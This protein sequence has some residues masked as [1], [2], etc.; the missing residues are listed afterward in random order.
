MKTIR[1]LAAALVTTIFQISPSIA[2]QTYEWPR[3]VV[4]GT[5]GTTTGSFASTNGWAPVLQRDKGISVRIVPEGNEMARYQRLTTKKTIQIASTSASEIRSQIEG[6]GAYGSVPAHP[7]RI[8]W[9]HNDTPWGYVTSATSDLKSLKDLAKGGY[10]VSVGVFSPALVTAVKEGLPAFAGLSPEEA[11]ERFIF[12]PASSYAENCRSVVEGKA[13][14]AL[15]SPI[16]SLLSEMEAAPGGIRWLEMDEEDIEAWKGYIAARPMLIPNKISMG[17]E[18]ARGVEGSTSN[19]LYMVAA[20]ADPEFAYNMA[21]WLAGSYDGYKSTHPLA[22]RMSADIFRAYLDRTP[23]PVHEGTVRYLKEAG[24]WSP[25]DEA[26][27]A[28]AITRMD[29]WVAARQAALVEAREAGI[30]PSPDN[31]DFVTILDKHT[32]ELSRFRSRL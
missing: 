3:L 13:D 5:P 29:S 4:I 31:P 15:C 12:V 17:V 1:I 20:D 2:Q 9:H 30:A 27:N 24:L 6:I 25:A 21:K 19:F 16:S 22:S 23:L 14:V 32:S 10:R 26:R 28:E 18:S 8:L 7:M 11:E